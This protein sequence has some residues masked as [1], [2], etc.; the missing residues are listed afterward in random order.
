MKIFL[1]ISERLVYLIRKKKK[2]LNFI[3]G[4]TDLMVLMITFQISFMVFNETR[5]SLFFLTSQHL[6]L[7]LI[8]VPAW[9]LMLQA[10][11]VA[12]I[13]R[14][15]RKNQMFIEFMQFSI[16]NL[17]VLFVF[18]YIFQLESVSALFIIFVALLGLVLLFSLRVIEYRIF[19]WYRKHGHN[20]LNVVLIADDSAETFIEELINRK[21]WGYKILFVFSDSKFLKSKYGDK[22]KFLPEKALRSLNFLLEFE[23]VDEVIY[24]KY[25]VDTIDIRQKIRSCEEIGIIFRLRSEIAPIFFTNGHLS[26]IG[27]IEF[28]TFVN[29]PTNS[30]WLAFK[31]AMD[32]YV[33]FVMI[34]MLM[35]VFIGIALLVKITSP[36]PIVFKQ[37]RVGLRG[38]QFYIYKFRTM[39]VNAEKLRA[40][41]ETANEMDGPVFKIKKDPRITSIGNI[42]RKTGLDE[43]PQL[44]NVL[45]GDM[46]LIGPR[47][48]LQSET[49]QYKRWQLRRLSVKPGITC[50]WQ[51]SP[52]RNN[53]KFEN[54]MKLDL[55]YIDN[56]SPKLDLI[57][58]IKTV[59]TVIFKTGS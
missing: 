41:L 52:D 20:F 56:W 34:A 23:I 55:D 54:W 31:T 44:F 58:L 50:S 12:Q 51:I 36:G 18:Y 32:T 9:I 33:S 15:G 14:T 25:T 13:P 42:L 27:N 57:L 2:W 53:I 45:K 24:Y 19:K 47:P 39:V 38:R 48:P 8:M 29:V 11:N 4:A 30:F 17:V 40:Q 37:A 10:S 35:P 6:V 46:S 43:L 22:V 5:N 1:N 28:L 26:R 16:M 3:L 49:R 59:R 21:D 7:F